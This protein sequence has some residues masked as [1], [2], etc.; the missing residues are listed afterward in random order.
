[1]WTCTFRWQDASFG[2]RSAYGA[3]PLQALALAIP[4]LEISL[5]S[6]FPGARIFMDG[7]PFISVESD[8]Q[9]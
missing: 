7:K 3:T 8:V 9:P 2:K 5:R 4:L 6:E 1:M